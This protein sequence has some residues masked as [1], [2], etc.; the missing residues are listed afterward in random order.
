MNSYLIKF[1]RGNDVNIEIGLYLVV[2]S[3]ISIWITQKDEYHILFVQ[4]VFVQY[5]L[6]Q[7][8]KNQNA[9]EN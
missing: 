7:F 8:E 4:L 6:F 2:I 9:Q 5:G 3:Y 1:L